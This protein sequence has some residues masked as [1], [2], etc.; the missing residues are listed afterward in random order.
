V[1]LESNLIRRI[2]ARIIP[3]IVVA[4]VVSFLDRVNIGIAA[5]QMNK[6]LGFS[7]TVYGFGAGLLALSY[8]LL[9][10]P[11]NLIL[12]KVGASKWLARIMV[13]W[14]LISGA[15]AFFLRSETGF[16][17][18]RLLL[19]AA[20]AGFVPGCLYLLA[21]WYPKRHRG[22]AL[23]YFFLSVPISISIGAP[24][25]GLILGMDG[26]AGLHGWQWL[27]VI[28]A[29]PSF[30]LAP[31]LY[32]GIADTPAKAK[33]LSVEE[34]L[35][36]SSELAKDNEVAA[37]RGGHSFIP[38]LSNPAVWILSIVYFGVVACA[39]CLYY[40]LP[41]IIKE[42][43][44]SNQEVGWLTAVPFTIGSVCMLV[45]G[46]YSDRHPGKRSLHASLALVLA[47]LGIGAAGFVDAP[48]AKMIAIS[49]ACIGI[50]AAQ[51]PFW[52]LPTALFTGSAAAAALAVINSI[53]NIA[54]FATPFG[55]GYLKDRT[56]SFSS[57]LLVVG[58]FGLLSAVVLHLFGRKVS[59]SHREDVSV[60]RV[61]L[62]PQLGSP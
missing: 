27:F 53:G 55:I 13:T 48:Q 49:V 60:D 38:G 37:A 4:F 31:V 12:E 21:L 26:F 10:V 46:R 35:W 16:Y 6:E 54:A 50:Y 57:G 19:G 25:S 47:G 18:I 15:Q 42:M 41:Q 29:I 45:W 28:E 1:D 7:A 11:S 40:F 62:K 39:M 24:I 61:E 5:L 17:V 59:A 58:G 23:S 8:C 56:G 52:S 51:P 9:E 32:Y 43:G 14:G 20:E 34:K 22:K 36:L 30:L 44:F 33:W 2:N 3:I